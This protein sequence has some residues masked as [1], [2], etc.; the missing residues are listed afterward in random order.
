MTIHTLPPESD[1]VDTPHDIPLFVWRREVLRQTVARLAGGGR[2]RY[3]EL[4][5]ANMARWALAASPQPRWVGALAED[6]GDVT[7]R[8][9]EEYGAVFAVLNMANAQV[10]GGGYLFGASGQEEDLFR[11]TDCHFCSE[12]GQRGAGGRHYTEAMTAQIEGLSGSVYLDQAEPRVC[13]RAPERHGRMAGYDWLPDEEV[14]LFY[15]MRAAARDYSKGAAFDPDDARQRI[16]AQLDT[17]VAAK[18]RH[19]VLGASGCGAFGNPGA[20]IAKIY[21]EEIMRRLDAFDCV[22]FAVLRASFAPGHYDVFRREFEEAPF[23]RS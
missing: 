12:A 5:R 6:W 3:R 8:L 10:P 11:R 9:S 23:A 22:A 15:E 14:F 13:I 21:R 4:G 19:V 1:F 2:G 17:L 18:Q 20:S 16:C 7:R